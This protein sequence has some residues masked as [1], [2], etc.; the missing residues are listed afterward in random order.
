M[1]GTTTR[2]WLPQFC[3]LPTLFAVMI[4]AELVALVVVLAPDPA[5]R[6]WLPRLGVASVY[7]QWLALLNAVVLCSMRQPLD[8]LSA[9]A[10]FVI[11]WLLSIVVTGV[12][13]A[14]LHFWLGSRTL[15][16]N[17]AAKHARR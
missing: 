14:Q 2:R 15:T 10:A 3:S 12:L 8:R 16:Q 9:R 13:W 7:V 1:N 11:A 6:P 17:I 5:L 4:V